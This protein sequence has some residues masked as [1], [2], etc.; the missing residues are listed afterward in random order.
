MNPSQPSSGTP[1]GPSHD[2]APS[3]VLQ[4]GSN[5]VRAWLLGEVETTPWH[6]GPPC[7]ETAQ[8]TAWLLEF[9]RAGFVTTNSQPGLPLTPDGSSMWRQRAWVD[10]TMTTSRARAIVTACQA[11]DLIALE[12]P[13]I[14]NGEDFAKMRRVPVTEVD[15]EEVTWMPIGIPSD[16]VEFAGLP[17]PGLSQ[18]TVI[19]LEWGRNDLWAT[20]AQALADNP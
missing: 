15:G 19:D 18:L 12:W 9:N 5:L 1:L 20:L 3:D 17:G 7:S 8:I 4:W 14:G 6:L 13:A 2:W 16:L 11:H 10:G